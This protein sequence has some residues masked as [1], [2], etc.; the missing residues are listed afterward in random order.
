MLKDSSSGVESEAEHR[1]VDGTG[2]DQDTGSVQVSLA[3][4]LPLKHSTVVSKDVVKQ[5][6]EDMGYE[7]H[8][9]ETGTE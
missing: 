3:S 2:S 4:F 9:T 8:I 7:D 1:V 6:A 5:A